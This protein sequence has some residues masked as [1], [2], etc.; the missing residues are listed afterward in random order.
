MNQDYT[1]I[2]CIIVDDC[3]PDDSILKCEKLIREYVG[4]IHFKIIHHKKN[5]G[6]SAARNTGI[7]AATGDYVF[8]LD[9]DDEI[10][11][12]CISK[13]VSAIRE[14]VSVEMVQ[15]GYIDNDLIDIYKQQERPSTTFY[16]IT[17][18][19]EVYKHYYHNIIY[20]TAWNKLI[21][22]SF[23]QENHIFSKKV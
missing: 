7:G 13:L 9:S 17:S 19:K 3:S 22:R 1:D 20:I 15:G 5:R 12:D 10:T 16:K 18:K 6:L 23:I 4:L 2:E 14:D 21:K 8:Y 11:K